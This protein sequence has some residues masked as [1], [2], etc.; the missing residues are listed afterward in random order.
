MGVHH[1]VAVLS[2]IEAWGGFTKIALRYCVVIAEPV[3]AAKS[4][5]DFSLCCVG[6]GQDFTAPIFGIHQSIARN[7]A[8]R[9]FT[10]KATC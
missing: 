2:D 5:S 10:L 1:W 6:T 4:F 9:E 3:G 7:F 8:G